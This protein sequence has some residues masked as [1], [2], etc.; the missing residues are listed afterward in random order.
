[1]TRQFGYAALICLAVSLGSAGAEP[2]IGRPELLEPAGLRHVAE[3]TFDLGAHYENP[4][5]PDEIAVAAIVTGP[6]GQNWLVPAFWFEPYDRKVDAT[7][8]E[9]VEWQKNPGQS[10]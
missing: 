8:L 4:Y 6:T 9:L 7:E 1:M 2:K 3:F 5:D 10:P